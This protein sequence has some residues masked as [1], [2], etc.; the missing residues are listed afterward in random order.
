MEKLALFIFVLTYIGLA[1]GSIPGLL[2]DR[3]GIALIG[4]SATILFG[5]LS[6]EEAIKYYRYINYTFALWSYGNFRSATDRWILHE[7][8]SSDNSEDILS[9][10]SPSEFDGCFG[11]NVRLSG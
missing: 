10:D 2:I 3:S 5:I 11:N 8:I 9:W 7:D 1:F 4:A 6:P